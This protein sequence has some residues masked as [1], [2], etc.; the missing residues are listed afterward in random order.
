[1]G[2]RG[3]DGG[4]GGGGGNGGGGGGSAGGDG[5]VDWQTHCL[6]E[7]HEPELR[8]PQITSDKKSGDE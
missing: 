4:D 2:A 3:A 5:G 8:V 7:E 6:Y 1:M